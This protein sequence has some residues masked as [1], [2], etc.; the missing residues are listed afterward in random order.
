MTARGPV[1]DVRRYLGVP[2][3]EDGRTLQ[4]MDC[5]GLHLD[6]LRTQL[7]IDLPDPQVTVRAPVVPEEWSRRF[8][9]V[10]PE[11][12]EVGDAIESDGHP[13]HVG[14]VIQD[15]RVLTTT[16]ESGVVTIAL[17]TYLR[18]VRVIACWRPR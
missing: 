12:V 1:V 13:H 8:L 3:V 11:K 7:G 5:L 17:R 16:R 10:E 4:G 2:W 9:Q 6:V 14:T 15:R 18:A